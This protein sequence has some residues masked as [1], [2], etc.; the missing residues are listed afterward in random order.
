MSNHYA[1]NAVSDVSERERTQVPGSPYYAAQAGLQG[2]APAVAPRLQAVAL[3]KSYR[4][5]QVEIPE[6]DGLVSQS[7]A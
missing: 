7:L 3:R 6:L 5:G 1:A 2:A 4:K